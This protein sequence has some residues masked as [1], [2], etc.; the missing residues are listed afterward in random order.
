MANLSKRNVWI[1]SVLFVGLLVVGY[2]LLQSKPD[3]TLPPRVGVIL[4][5]DGRIEG[6]EGLQTGLVELGY[7]LGKDLT[8]EI[9]NAANDRDFLAQLVDNLIASQPDVVVALGGIEAEEAK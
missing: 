2:F 5:G 8:L 9:V 7:V 6:L 1:G 3:E 4:S